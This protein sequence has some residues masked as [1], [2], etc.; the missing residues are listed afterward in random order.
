MTS[1][2]IDP[3]FWGVITCINLGIGLITPPV[4]T[5]LYVASGVAKVSMEQLVK[6]LL[7]FF[8]GMV[9]LL[10]LLIAFPSLITFLPNL[11]MPAN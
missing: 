2:G 11:L 5:V 3:V 6:A 8:F 7:P 1:Y 10:V 4:G 9:F